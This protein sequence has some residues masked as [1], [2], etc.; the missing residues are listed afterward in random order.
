MTVS[1]HVANGAR[2]MT[3]KTVA[4][5]QQGIADAVNAM[6]VHIRLG[7]IAV[8]VQPAEFGPMG[9][10]YGPES[11][12]IFI[13]PDASDIKAWDS[14][15]Y[16]HLAVHELSHV[17]RWQHLPL[18]TFDDWTPGEVLSLEGHATQTEV[19]LGLPHYN[20]TDANEA[21]VQPLLDRLTPDVARPCKDV[22]WFDG[23]CDLPDGIMRAA[24][25]MGHIVFGRYLK[26]S[27][28]TPFSAIAAPWQE[29][30]DVGATA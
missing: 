26:R 27:G 23:T 29:I 30:W 7:D 22:D 21:D 16:K 3:D 9:R 2:R 24:G 20:I 13:N 12:S 4:D 19:F 6:E 25:P 15:R 14:S 5:V 28:Q 10:A 1:V 17:L 11:F 18:K 8:F